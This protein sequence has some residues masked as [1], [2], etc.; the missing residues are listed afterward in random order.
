M[1]CT[2]C[3]QPVL[4]SYYFCPNCGAKLNTPPLSTSI[5]S[6]VQL[7]LFSLILPVICYLA[8]TKWKGVKYVKSSDVKTKNIGIIACVLLGLSSIV[9]IWYAT[10][11][12]QNEIQSATSQ[13]GADL[14]GY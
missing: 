7:Y 2:I 3:H 6:Q 9:T 1:V 4:P 14:S 5:S 8:I 12:T 13:L 11:W 10:V